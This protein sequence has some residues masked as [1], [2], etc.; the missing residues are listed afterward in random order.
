MPN[1]QPSSN[2]PRRRR[3]RC[4]EA[5]GRARRCALR[6]HRGS[7]TG[8]LMR[9][10]KSARRSWP[11]SLEWPGTPR[12]PGQPRPSRPSP[13]SALPTNTTE[14]GTFPA[15]ASGAW[16]GRAA[17]KGIIGRHG[18]G[19][20]ATFGG[21]KSV[22]EGRAAAWGGGDGP[23]P[24]RPWGHRT[25]GVDRSPAMLDIAREKVPYAT[26]ELGDLTDLPLE[27][28]SVDLAVCRRLCG[29]TSPAACSPAPRRL[30]PRSGQTP[31]LAGL[32]PRVSQ[33]RRD[34][35]TVGR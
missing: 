24:P 26:F 3:G 20:V 18:V 30:P 17:R 28:A 32:D 12:P 33:S 31:R 11:A 27:E 4:H 34:A 29:P 35:R 21:A 9:N 16:S 5:T 13:Y 1:E 23:P 8:Y 6:P 14:P 7:Q 10:A 25:I 15:V 2:G 19:A 22:A